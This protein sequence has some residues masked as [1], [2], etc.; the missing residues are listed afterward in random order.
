MSLLQASS[1]D[2]EALVQGAAYLGY[3][4]LSRTTEQV[5]VDV[6]GAVYTFDVLAALEFNSDR[7]RMSIIV[8][9]P[10]N[11]LMLMC[12]GADSMILARLAP[13]EPGVDTVKA[14]LVSNWALY[15]FVSVLM[16]FLQVALHV[17]T[18]GAKWMILIVI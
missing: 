8:R 15:W 7:K 16:T 2:E 5:K 11:K 14:H 12:K 9:T 4:L 6:H 3:K 13:G 18:P 1:P 10:E 17:K